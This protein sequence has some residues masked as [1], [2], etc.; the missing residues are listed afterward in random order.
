MRI[1]LD[2]WSF[3]YPVLLIDAYE[4]RFYTWIDILWEQD[5]MISIKLMLIWTKIL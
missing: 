2:F 1:T 4:M 5:K 3:V